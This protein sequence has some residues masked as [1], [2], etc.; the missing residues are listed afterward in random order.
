MTL[1]KH[2]IAAKH[3]RKDAVPSR[4]FRLF[5]LWGGL[6]A[7]FV[8][9]VLIAV[10]WDPGLADFLFLLIAMW[11]A[12]IRYV[13]IGPIGKETQQIRPKAL[14]EWRRYSIKLLLASGFLYALARIVATQR[15]I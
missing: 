8:F 9:A 1:A 3:K 5:C 14:R 13:E 4:R 12:L 6:S 2:R 11:M 7:L 15:L 10:R